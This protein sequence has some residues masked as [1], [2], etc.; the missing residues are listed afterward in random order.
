MKLTFIPTVHH[1]Y[2]RQNNNFI[3]KLEG[4]VANNLK[5]QPINNIS[6]PIFKEPLAINKKP[7]CVI[8]L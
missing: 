2:V 1:I 7:R 4:K 5:K 3:Y 8:F 6:N